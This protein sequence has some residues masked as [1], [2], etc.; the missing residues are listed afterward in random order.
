[1]RKQHV[2]A[3]H[4]LVASEQVLAPAELAQ[5]LGEQ[6]DLPVAI[7]A[8]VG[9]QRAGVDQADAQTQPIGGRQVAGHG[10]RLGDVFE[11]GRRLVQQFHV[12][13]ITRQRG[14]SL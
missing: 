4:L 12:G 6:G 2:A 10:E 5:V 1:M 7:E 13:E 9:E 3:E 8:A 14:R 11:A